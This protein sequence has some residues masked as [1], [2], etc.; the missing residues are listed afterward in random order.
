M[1]PRAV[2]VVLAVAAAVGA[3][4]AAA[5]NSPPSVVVDF[6]NGTFLKMCKTYTVGAVPSLHQKKHVVHQCYGP[7]KLAVRPPA[8]SVSVDGDGDLSN[9]TWLTWTA[10]SATGSG[11]VAVRCFGESTDPH[12]AGRQ[13]EYQAPARVRLT[14]PVSTSRGVVFTVLSVT[15]PGARTQLICLPP[16][17][18]C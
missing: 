13:F 5:G 10:T 17:S 18:A 14:T 4:A 15:R 2:L 1:T 8:I 16:A 7:S 6:P 9:L 11:L 3:G 12:C